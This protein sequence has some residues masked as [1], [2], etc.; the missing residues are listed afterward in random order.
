TLASSFRLGSLFQGFAESLY[1]VP[2]PFEPGSKKYMMYRT[3]LED[4]A[5]PLEDK[6]IK[7]YKKTIKKAREEKIVNEWTKKT[8]NELNKYRPKEF[9]LY[10]ESKTAKQKH[11]VT[12][13]PLLTEMPEIKKGASSLEDDSPDNP[14]DADSSTSGEDGSGDGSDSTSSGDGQSSNSGETGGEGQSESTGNPD[15]GNGEKDS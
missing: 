13:R 8:L 5:I 10:K 12:G 9:P 15:Q 2:I 14:N 11:T 4:I 7:R 3:Q 6:A 1:K